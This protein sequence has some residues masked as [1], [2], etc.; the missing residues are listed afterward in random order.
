MNRLLALG[1]GKQ[2]LD[3]QCV[4]PF[5]KHGGSEGYEFSGKGLG[6]PAALI[7]ARK[8]VNDWQAAKGSAVFELNNF[9][10]TP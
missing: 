10:H 7:H 5:A 8:D 6:R 4:V 9:A 1:V 2:Q 3:A